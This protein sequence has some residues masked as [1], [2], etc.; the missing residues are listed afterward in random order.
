M[1]KVGL[2]LSFFVVCQSFV[3]CTRVVSVAPPPSLVQDG[4]SA[5]FLSQL[6]REFQI[7]TLLQ[8][9][10]IDPHSR[11]LQRTVV[12][13]CE[14]YNL[15]LSNSN[16][17]DKTMTCA[18]LN[19]EQDEIFVDC[20]YDEPSCNTD[21]ENNVTA[22]IEGGFALTLNAEGDHYKTKSCFNVTTSEVLQ[23]TCVE[24]VTSTPKDFS[25]V[26]SCAATLNEEACNYCEV[27]DANKLTV[28]C[29][30]VV[31]DKRQSECTE[32]TENGG[33]TPIYDTVDTPGQC[34]GVNTY[35]GSSFG[36]RYRSFLGLLM[37]G[38]Q[39]VFLA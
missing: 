28:D 2:V 17:T 10:L 16:V 36:V 30:N 32:A 33:F 11:R 24:V 14:Q 34:T 23:N 38:L 31:D 1:N 22:C 5:T 9:I 15:Q 13:V 18:C 21:I 29:C 39:I 26:E 27:C 3:G 25:I 6:I 19:L 4:D 37:G 20:V 12:E 35:G 8:D 7:P